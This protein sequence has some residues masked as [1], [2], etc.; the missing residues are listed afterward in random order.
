MVGIGEVRMN[1]E[2]VKAVCRKL[3]A[4]KKVIK[5]IRAL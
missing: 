3:C 2:F 5:L 4:I 1:N